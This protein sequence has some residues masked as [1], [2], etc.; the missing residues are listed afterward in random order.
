MGDVSQLMPAIHP[1]VEAASGLGHG[2]D[3]LIDDYDLGV[4][5]ASKIM[6]MTVID[7]MTD[8]PRNGQSLLKGYKAALSKRDYLA[9][10]RGMLKEESFNE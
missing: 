7:L 9:L 3:Y 4:L 6:A 5:T 1:Y 10:L 2:K 8:G